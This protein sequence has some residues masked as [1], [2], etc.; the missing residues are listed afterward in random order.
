MA[1]YII[2]R[3]VDFSDAENIV[4]FRNNPEINK[5]LSSQKVISIEEQIKWMLNNEN[6]STNFYFKIIRRNDNQF[7]GTISLYNIENNIAEF[8]RYICIDPIGAIEAELSIIEFAFSQSKLEKIYCRTVL[9]NTKVIIQHR[10]FG[11]RDIKKVYD[12]KIG[13]ELLIQELNY[14]G[15]SKF[16]Y[17]FIKKLVEKFTKK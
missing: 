16:D 17:H 9:D 1:E 11:F 7:I 8:G 6:S 4:A 13:R 5:Y 2:L 12:P 10:K 15:F 3:P 14:E